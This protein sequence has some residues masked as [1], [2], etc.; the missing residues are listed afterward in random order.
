MKMLS[1]ALRATSS[2]RGIPRISVSRGL[3]IPPRDEIKLQL[4][5]LVTLARPRAIRTPRHLRCKLSLWSLIFR[6]YTKRAKYEALEKNAVSGPEMPQ[7]DNLR[8]GCNSRKASL[9]WEI[10]GLFNHGE[11]RGQA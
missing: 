7:L 11:I 6:N 10:F 4:P 9:Y 8:Y 1:N 2:W 5:S 3:E